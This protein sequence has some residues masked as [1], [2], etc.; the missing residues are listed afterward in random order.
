MRKLRTNQAGFTIIEVLAAMGVA[1]LL[2]VI[3]M[4]I[5]TKTLPAIRLTDAARQI[6]TELQHARMKAIAESMPHQISFL[7]TKYHV[8]RCV[9]GTCTAT[10]DRQNVALPEGITVTPPASPPQF[11]ARG[12][13]SSAATIKI[14]NGSTDKWVCVKIVGRINVQDT[15]CT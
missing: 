2:M 3:G 14:S 4:P 10:V 15:V 12:T 11:Q 1:G 7:S 5:F 8:E 6:A 9:A 13:V